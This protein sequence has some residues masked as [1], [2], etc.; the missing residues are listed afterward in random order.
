[1]FHNS[2]HRDNN[3]CAKVRG[4]GSPPT[5][6]FIC[7]GFFQPESISICHILGV[8]HIIVILSLTAFSS[9][10][11][12]SFLVSSLTRTTQAPKSRGKYISITIASKEIVVTANILSFALIPGDIAKE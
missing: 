3:L 6:A 4:T 7:K 1:M 11:F 8:P 2:L 9:N 12:P 10:K 5:K